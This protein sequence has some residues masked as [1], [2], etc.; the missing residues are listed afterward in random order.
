LW[1]VGA[2]L[3]DADMI[4]NRH[5]DEAENPELDQDYRLSLTQKRVSNDLTPAQLTEARLERSHDR[6]L[7]Q[8]NRLRQFRPPNATVIQHDCPGV[9][10]TGRDPTNYFFAGSKPKPAGDA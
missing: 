6:G 1:T 2:A 8:F 9:S 10:T 3:A 4:L 5:K 7:N